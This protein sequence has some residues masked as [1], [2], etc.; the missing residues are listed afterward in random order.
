M[1]LV[2]L[3]LMYNFIVERIGVIFDNVIFDNVEF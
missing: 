2:L 1:C 3:D